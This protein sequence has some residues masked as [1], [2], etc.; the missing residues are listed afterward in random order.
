M[1]LERLGMRHER[2]KLNTTQHA[3][4]CVH[5]LVCVAALSSATAQ[6]YEVLLLHPIEQRAPE[7]AAIE[8][9]LRQEF[10]NASIDATQV[11]S[12]LVDVDFRQPSDRRIFADYLRAK[13]ADVGIDAIVALSDEAVQF[14]A[15][16]RDVIGDVPLV[17]TTRTSAG[18]DSIPK[19]SSVVAPLLPS[20]TVEL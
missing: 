11:Y 19:S 3:R 8:V 1:P 18:T 12:E 7:Y 5:F 20:R 4:S 17:F 16:H 2:V 9:G 6:A 15:E 10:A 13:Y 14:V